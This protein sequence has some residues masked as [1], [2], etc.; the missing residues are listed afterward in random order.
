MMTILKKAKGSV[1]IVPVFTELT[2][3]KW[4]KRE[5]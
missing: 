2:T 4:A 3:H 1:F 5:G